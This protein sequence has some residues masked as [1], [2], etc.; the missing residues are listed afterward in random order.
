MEQSGARKYVSLFL[1]IDKESMKV[2]IECCGV[3]GMGATKFCFYFSPVFGVLLRLPRE[4]WGGG[5][6]KRERK[7]PRKDQ[8]LDGSAATVRRLGL[9]SSAA[10]GT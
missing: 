4:R 5:L 1:T 10:A 3:L 2:Y 7:G 8:L 9:R 6:P